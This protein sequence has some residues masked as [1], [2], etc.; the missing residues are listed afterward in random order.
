[1]VSSE[2]ICITRSLYANEAHNILITGLGTAQAI[3]DWNA[4]LCSVYA[5]ENKHFNNTW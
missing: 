1:M 4:Y 2:W 3:H 5:E